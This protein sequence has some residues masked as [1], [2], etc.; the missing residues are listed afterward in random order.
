MFAVHFYEN[1]SRVLTQALRNIPSVNEPIKIK[2]KKGKVINITEIEGNVIHVHVEF[3]KLVVK[4]PV[5][6]KDLGKKKKR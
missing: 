1:N 6:S 5:G 2:G 4:N 3:E